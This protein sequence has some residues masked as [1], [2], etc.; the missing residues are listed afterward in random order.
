MLSLRAGSGRELPSSLLGTVGEDG[1][2]MWTR[3]TSK[4]GSFRHRSHPT[5]EHSSVTARGWAVLCSARS[6]DPATSRR[7]YTHTSVLSVSVNPFSD[8]PPLP[9][10]TRRLMTCQ[11]VSISNDRLLPHRHKD[12]SC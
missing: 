6:R 8:C 5:R 1:M 10:G 2:T 7:A 12:P 3:R 11:T 9:K 4:L